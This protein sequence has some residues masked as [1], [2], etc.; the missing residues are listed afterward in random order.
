[1]IRDKIRLL[2]SKPIKKVLEAK[3]PQQAT[4]RETHD[5]RTEEDGRRRPHLGEHIL[6]L[7]LRKRS[8][9]ARR[10]PT[11]NKKQSVLCKGALRGVKGRPKGVKGR[12]KVP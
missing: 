1:M 9:S 6:A 2:D 7:M 10:Q 5:Q 3:E 12:Y 11:R 8:C 4:C